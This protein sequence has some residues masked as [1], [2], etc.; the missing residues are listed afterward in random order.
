MLTQERLKELVHYDPATG[1]FTW[2]KLRPKCRPGDIAG[3][4]S[5]G[6]VVIKLD[7]KDYR[8][9]RL[10]FLY[11]TGEVPPN[12]VDHENLVRSDNRWDNL[13]PATHSQNQWNKG[14]QCNNK[15]GVVGVS[16]YAPTGKWRA[17]CKAYGKEHSV[18][19]FDT[20]EQAATAVAAKRLELHGE[21]ARAA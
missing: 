10:A 19:Y 15:T 20:L 3:R 11:M 18:G 17:R 1:L 5:D 21:F 8:A 4:E 9:H 12:D 14:P 6:Y 13:R 2:N 7:Y 16:W